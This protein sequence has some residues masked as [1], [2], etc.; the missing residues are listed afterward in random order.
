MNHMYNDYQRIEF[1]IHHLVWVICDCS[2]GIVSD[3]AIYLEYLH[4][5][6]SMAIMN[7]T[8]SVVHRL[9]LFEENG[10]QFVAV[11]VAVE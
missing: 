5:N 3:K 11:S 4:H 7:T 9:H 8:D 2:S 1:I 10:D 6:T